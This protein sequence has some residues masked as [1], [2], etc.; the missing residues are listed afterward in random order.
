MEDVEL[1]SRL[2]RAGRLA[3]LRLRVATSARRWEANGVARTI[4]LM[5]AL[6]LA[7]ACGVSPARLAR[8]YRRPSD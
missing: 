2:R 3:A 8:A 4:V 1:T 6:R 5:W 7:Y